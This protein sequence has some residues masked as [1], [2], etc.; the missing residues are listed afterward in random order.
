MFFFL[1]FIFPFFP[2]KMA[3]YNSAVAPLTAAGPVIV[4]NG[5]DDWTM[6]TGVIQ[7]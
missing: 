7:H 4:R 1:R 6:D 3:F 2:A 5:I